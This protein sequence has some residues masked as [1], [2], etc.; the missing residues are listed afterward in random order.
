MVRLIIN[1]NEHTVDEPSG[2]TL[3]DALREDLHLA[4]AKY[5][6]SEGQCGACTVLLD[7][8]AVR[9]CMVDV[10]MLDGCSVT[11]VEGLA[12]EGHLHAVQAALVEAR[13]LQCGYCTPGMV[14]SA[15]ALLA[16]DRTP[17]DATISQALAGNICRCSGYSR[18][19]QAVH[20][21]A[22]MQRDVNRGTAT[23]QIPLAEAVHDS[24]TGADVWTVVLAP[25][26]SD[27]R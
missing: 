6:C 21:A 15:V 5:G 17:N 25:A 23:D 11:T 2:L 26:Q 3:L 10:E 14:M 20:T 12:R 16:R 4:G 22:A 7:G 19:L 18:I 24:A 9:S 1:G 27:P 8:V 13:S